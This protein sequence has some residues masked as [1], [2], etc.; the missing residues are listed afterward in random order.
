M[1][2]NRIA[3]WRAQHGRQGI[4]QAHL[5]RQLKVS[6]SYI[7]KLEHGRSQPSAAMMFRL[8]QYFGCRIEELFNYVPDQSREP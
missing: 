5:A 4:N 8:A 6:R 1:M 3:A 2:T 7:A